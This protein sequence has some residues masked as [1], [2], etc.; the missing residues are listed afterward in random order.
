LHADE[1][2]AYSNTT[3]DSKLIIVTRFIL[4]TKWR[5]K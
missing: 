3:L 4:H 1:G 5:R 2:S